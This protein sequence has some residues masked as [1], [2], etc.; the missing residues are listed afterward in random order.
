M[1]LLLLLY[2]TLFH[3]IIWSVRCQGLKYYIQVPITRRRT[4]YGSSTT[5]RTV[6]DFVELVAIRVKPRS[7]HLAN[8]SDYLFNKSKYYCT[9][10][11]KNRTNV[12]VF[13][14]VIENLPVI[15]TLLSC[16]TMSKHS[17]NFIYRTMD[18]VL[19]TMNGA[20][21]SSIQDLF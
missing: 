8:N 3:I 6:S 16:I 11:F 12:L 5:P 14:N 21:C 10:C 20:F 7:R 19:F 17:C 4:A 1:L 13:K 2:F 15:L 9:Q 18:R